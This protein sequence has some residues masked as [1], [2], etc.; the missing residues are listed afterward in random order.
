MN[1]QQLLI[2]ERKFVHTQYPLNLKFAEYA[3]EHSMNAAEL[4]FKIEA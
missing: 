1:P 4:K 3:E 2:E